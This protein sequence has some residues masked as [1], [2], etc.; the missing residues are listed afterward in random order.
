MSKS[1]VLNL[2]IDPDLKKEAKRIAADDD[3][4]LSNWV[5]WLIKREVKAAHSKGGSDSDKN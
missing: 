3:R 2:R 5:T 4:S 1:N